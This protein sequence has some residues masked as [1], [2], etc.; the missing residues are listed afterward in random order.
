MKTYYVYQWKADPKAKNALGIPEGACIKGEPFDSKA[1][2]WAFSDLDK[3]LTSLVCSKD[4]TIENINGELK[5]TLLKVPDTPNF[6]GKS[7]LK[8][9]LKINALGL[10]YDLYL[11]QS[12]DNDD[13]A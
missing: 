6:K 10:K 4:M 11:K 12:S 1:S 13:D 5:F 7:V 8:N 2:A 9:Y 3:N